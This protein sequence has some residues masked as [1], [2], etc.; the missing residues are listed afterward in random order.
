[1]TQEP[2]PHLVCSLAVPTIISMLVSSF[3][4]MVDTFFVG[5][6]NTS[7]TAAVGIVFSLM[8]IIQAIGF[9]F[10]HGSGNYISR[11]LGAQEMEEASLMA[12]FGFFAALIA[13]TLLMVGGLVFIG[14]L[15]RALGSTETIM[16]YAIDYLRFILVG[17]PYMTASLVLNNQLRFQGNAF[18]GM[19]GIVSGAV[20]NIVLDPILIFGLGMG[21][22]GA[23]LA[24]IISQFVSFVILL[25]F[26]LK[27]PGIS[28]RWKNFHPSLHLMKEIAR[29]GF[30]SLCRQG[31]A[32]VAT[33]ALNVAAGA[34][35]DAAIAGM[36]IVSRVSMFANSALIGFGQGFQPV[37]GFNYGAKLFHRVREAFYFCVKYATLFLFLVSVAG[38]LGAPQLVRIFR[39]DD[40]EVAAVGIA[41]LRFTCISFT[42][43]G[44]IV[45]SN[46]FLQSIGMATRAS[47]VA[48]ARQGLFFLPLIAI[49]PSV[50]GV[51]GIEMCQMISDILT[52]FV[53]L[54]LALGVLKKMKAA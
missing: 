53:A 6:I 13:G 4:N 18:Y 11:K 50:F 34:Y 19:I 48:A 8:A 29:G 37:C 12:S 28:I 51:Q 36:S 22:G 40:L 43:N 54:P 44:W 26:A 16:P 2:I 21:I 1:M 52:F 39:K 41:A 20:I 38:F 25:S 23:A 46:M 3:Y 27:G 14:P 7:A 47:I 42:L 9:F 30:P 15:A 32:S 35:G 33:I 17:A 10:G 45:M 24:T 49:L 5:R 31:L